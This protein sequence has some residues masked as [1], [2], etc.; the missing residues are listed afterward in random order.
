MKLVILDAKTLGSDISLKPFYALG[1]VTVYDLTKPEE[2]PERIEDATV[3]I[4]NKVPLNR[5]NLKDAKNLKLI[6]LTATRYNNVDLEYVKENQIAVTNVGGYSTNSVVQHTFALLL[7]LLEQLSFYDD[8]VKS[9]TYAKSDTFAYL[10]R[11]FYEIHGKV[12]GIIGLG[13]I[14]K[15]V[16]KV[17]KAFGASVCY[18]S[19]SGKN[20]QEEYNPVS[21]EELLKRSDIVSIH[22]P[23]NEHTDNLLTYKEMKLM[24]SNAILLNLGR[25]K[26]VN[27]ED[28]ARI[29][30][31]DAIRG[32]A[33]DVLEEE[34]INEENP[35]YTVGNKGKWLVTPH[36]AWGSVEARTLL[37]DEVVKNIIAFEKGEERNRIV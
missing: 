27:E 25:G 18:Y 12:W 23:L 19:T 26:I 6:A 5:T 32:A 9:K 16:A 4:T 10:G 28:L 21:L 7:N 33:L 13:T 20:R 11:P 14:G 31:E 22:A 35:L 36:I 37:V 1:E 24:K 8:Y 30:D 29:L 34:P 17:A 2:V 3:V 15:E